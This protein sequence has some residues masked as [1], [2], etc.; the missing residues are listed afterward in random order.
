MT[1]N[2][3]TQPGNQEREETP[4]EHG[5]D[6]PSVLRD[7]ADE[8]ESGRADDARSRFAQS[9]CFQYQASNLVASNDT[10]D[11]VKFLVVGWYVHTL[12]NT[13]QPQRG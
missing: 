6:V 12:L 13:L 11:V 5:T 3:S 8:I 4:E 9:F 7:I 1:E 10:E 2:V